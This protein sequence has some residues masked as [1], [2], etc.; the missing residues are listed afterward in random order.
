MIQYYTNIV[1]TFTCCAFYSHIT[2]I[3][4]QHKLLGLKMNEDECVADF[5]LCS[6]T[7]LTYTGACS[8]EYQNIKKVVIETLLQWDCKNQ[9]YK[10]KG[11]VGTIRAFAAG[12]EEQGRGTLHGHWQV[13]VE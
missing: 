10:G 13:Y 2:L 7:R 3:T 12:D 1:I 5:T 8:L 4:F 9:R 6:R 11:R